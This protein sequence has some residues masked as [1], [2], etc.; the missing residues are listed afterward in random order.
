MKNYKAAIIF[1][2]VNLLITF[3]PL[4]CITFMPD[5]FDFSK[6]DSQDYFGLIIGAV[7]SIFGIMMAVII[8]SVEFFKERLTKKTT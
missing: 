1:A 2:L 3:L 6:L 7:S 5:I 8:L 4:E